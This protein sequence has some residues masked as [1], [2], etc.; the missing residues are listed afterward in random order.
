MAPKKAA[1]KESGGGSKDEVD[2]SC[3]LFIRAYRKNCQTMGADF[4]PDMKKMIDE[5]EGQDISKVRFNFLSMQF[6]Y[7]VLI[8]A[9]FTFRMR[10]AG[11]GP[12]RCL[13][14]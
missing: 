11:K 10:S 12:S 5:L 4:S 8:L 13:M 1:K 6:I 7:D 3:E 2:N 9:R 14:L